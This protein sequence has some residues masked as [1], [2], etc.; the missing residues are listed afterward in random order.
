VSLEPASPGKNNDIEILRAF[1]I[2]Y[3]II[4]HFRVLLDADSILL[5][6]HNHLDLSVGVDYSSSFRASSSP[7]RL[8]NRQQTGPPPGARSCFPS[9]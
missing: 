9:G 1:A 6:P 3:T 2:L 8:L 4:L 7:A 5:I